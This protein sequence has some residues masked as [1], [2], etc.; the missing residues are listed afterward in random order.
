[1]A[2]E[3]LGMFGIRIR[4]IDGGEGVPGDATRGVVQV[5]DC[6]SMVHAIM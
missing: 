1:M 4:S 5:L 3:E 2:S 6:S